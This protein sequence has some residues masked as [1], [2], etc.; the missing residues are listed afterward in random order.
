M[1]SRKTTSL[2]FIHTR[3]LA[4]TADSYISAEFIKYE[5]ETMVLGRRDSKQNYFVASKLRLETTRQFC[6]ECYFFRTNKLFLLAYLMCVFRKLLILPF[7]QLSIRSIIFLCSSFRFTKWIDI[8]ELLWWTFLIPT[9]FGSVSGVPF[10]D[11]TKTSAD[12][13]R[14]WQPEHEKGV[15]RNPQKKTDREEMLSYPWPSTRGMLTRRS[16]WKEAVAVD[17]RS[18]RKNLF[19]ENFI[20]VSKRL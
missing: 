15:S 13:W 4:R 11:V 16:F 17:F 1:K 18:G 8:H 20:R 2:S 5:D 6:F 19:T 14:E 10:S 3:D 7:V 9:R 12:L